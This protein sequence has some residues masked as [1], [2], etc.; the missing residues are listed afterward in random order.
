MPAHCDLF[1]TS[2]QF[3]MKFVFF[4]KIMIE[5]SFFLNWT[6]SWQLRNN[7]KGYFIFECILFIKMNCS[8]RNNSMLFL[9]ILSKSE[10]TTKTT[11]LFNRPVIYYNILNLKEIEYHTDFT[12]LK[13]S[14]LL[15]LIRGLLLEPFIMK[16]S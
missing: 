11:T 16:K 10:I 8:I 4:Y 3:I 15:K 6:S 1:N 2:C 5:I 14:N 9:R 7:N 13:S 12:Y